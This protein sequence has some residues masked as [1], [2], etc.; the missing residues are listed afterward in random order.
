MVLNP[1]TSILRIR[2]ETNTHRGEANYMSS[3]RAAL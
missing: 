2:E 3:A 1:K